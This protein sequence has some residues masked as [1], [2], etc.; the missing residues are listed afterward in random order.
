VACRFSDSLRAVVFVTGGLLSMIIF[1]S[2]FA[3]IV[4]LNNKA[5]TFSSCFVFFFKIAGIFLISVSVLPD[6][7]KHCKEKYFVMDEHSIADKTF[8][9]IYPSFYFGA[10]AL[11]IFLHY[12]DAITGK[13]AMVLV[14]AILYLL[15]VGIY[16][17]KKGGV[18]DFYISIRGNCD[19]NNLEEN[20][21]LNPERIINSGVELINMSK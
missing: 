6:T 3:V 14:L 21:I 20:P 1:L 16:V 19:R 12:F 10:N 2:Y 5:E 7:L 17:Y 18:R 9:I 13:T 4:F 11:P 15:L 8:L